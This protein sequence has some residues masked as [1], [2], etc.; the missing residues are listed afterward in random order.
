VKRIL[1]LI[2]TLD[3]SGAEKQLTLLATGLPRDEFQVE[4][5]CL[6]RSGPYADVLEENGITVTVIG[7]KLRFSPFA[8]SKLRKLINDRQPD[9]LHT[10]LF[11]ANSFGRMAVG[12]SN[13]PHVIVSERCVDTWKAKW[14][15]WLDRK[16]IKKTTHLVGNSQAVADFYQ[17]LGMPAD[18]LSVIHNGIDVPGEPEK[19]RAELL[20]DFDIPESAF[21]VGYVGRLAPQKRISDLV[22]AFELLSCHDYESRLVIIGEG[23]DQKKAE[24]F[25]ED[26][27]CNKNIRWLGHRTDAH[28]LIATLDAFWLASDFEGQSN[29]LMEAMSHGVPCIASD[30]APNRELLGE[31]GIL[32]PVG[33]RGELAMQTNLLLRDDPRRQQLGQAAKDRI[34]TSFSVQRM[35]ESHCELYR[36]VTPVIQ[37]RSASE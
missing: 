1:F 28:E 2:P 31:T 4:V 7:K 26:I 22:A 30:I 8:L 14:Q 9:I 15:L 6:T 36:N 23:P 3:R 29:S 12:K 34:Q 5:V 19:T 25:A 20:A 13:K 33:D 10:W 27:G 32:F 18:R 21:T 24:T 37:P 11:A 35:V 16:L 17:D